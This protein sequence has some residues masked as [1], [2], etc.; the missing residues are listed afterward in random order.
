MSRAIEIAGEGRT[1][2]LLLSKIVS[3]NGFIVEEESG[4]RGQD[5]L[6]LIVPSLRSA[7]EFRPVIVLLDLDRRPCAVEYRTQF[8]PETDRF[9]IRI[10]VRSIESWLFADA[11]RLAAF[12]RIGAGDVPSDPDSVQNPKRKMI[13]LASM[14][15]DRRITR[16]M[17]PRKRSGA[18]EGPSYAFFLQSFIL[19]KWRPR[20]ARRYSD[21]LN[22]AMLRLE[23]LNKS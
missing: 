3:T 5:D 6:A 14:S 12:L 9:I 13:H 2:L 15:G 17:V 19:D 10:A 11:P 23:K 1:D 18:T 4:G 20:I 22:R 7:A 8:P 16:A 21:S